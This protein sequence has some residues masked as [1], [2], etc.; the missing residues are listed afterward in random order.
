MGLVAEKC[1]SKRRSENQTNPIKKRHRQKKKRVPKNR[2]QKKTARTQKNSRQKKNVYPKTVPKKFYHYFCFI[3][4]IGYTFW[5]HRFRLGFWIVLG[6]T[7]LF[8]DQF[9]DRHFPIC[10]CFGSVHFRIGFR[11]RCWIVCCH[12][13]FGSIIPLVNHNLG[14]PLVPGVPH[15]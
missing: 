9:L 15:A 11:I 4:K 8:L 3:K 10:W 6:S 14:K 12:C 7:G 5:V 13:A 1:Q 2:T